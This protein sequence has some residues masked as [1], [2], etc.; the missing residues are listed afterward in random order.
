MSIRKCP[1]SESNIFVGD[2]PDAGPISLPRPQTHES[3][4]QISVHTPRACRLTPEQVDN[5]LAGFSFP[6]DNVLAGFSFPADEYFGALAAERAR[7][8]KRRRRSLASRAAA[9]KEESKLVD[10]WLR[11]PDAR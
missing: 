7:A 11:R 6:A 9:A 4:D 3:R 10:E 1:T 5:V 8:A 2:R